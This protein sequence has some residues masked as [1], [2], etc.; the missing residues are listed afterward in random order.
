MIKGIMCPWRSNLTVNWS[1][2]AMNLPQRIIFVGQQIGI[3][4]DGLGYEIVE[5][6]GEMV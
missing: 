5:S 3:D 2:L 6:A 1:H 4:V